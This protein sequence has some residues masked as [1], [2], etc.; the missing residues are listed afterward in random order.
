[1]AR[2][3][4]QSFPWLGGLRPVPWAIGRQSVAPREACVAV[5]PTFSAEQH[6]GL[7]E[8]AAQ[9]PRSPDCAVLDRQHELVDVLKGA[10]REAARA[11]HVVHEVWC[12]GLQATA[13]I[14][15]AGP[16]EF[17]GKVL[18]AGERD[19]HATWDGARQDLDELGVAVCAIFRNAK[20]FLE[21]R[22]CTAAQDCGHARWALRRHL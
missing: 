6:R 2:R 10:R 15:E 5:A 1:M 22:L 14:R 8:N 17:L 19:A 12:N 18:R 16:G 13:K 20:Q 3:N 11:L 4:Q 7:R 9:C 21:A